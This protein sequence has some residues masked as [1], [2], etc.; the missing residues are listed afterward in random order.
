MCQRRN[1]SQIRE[2]FKLKKTKTINRHDCAT[3][4]VWRKMCII[5]HLCLKK[6]SHIN[7]FIEN[8]EKQRDKAH[9]RVRNIKQDKTNPCKAHIRVRC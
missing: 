9:S 8:L 5:K 6:I 7:D 1:K 4:V 3:K 2:Y